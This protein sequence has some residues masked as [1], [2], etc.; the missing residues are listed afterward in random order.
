MKSLDLYILRQMWTPFLFATVTV[1]AIVW[2]TQS[3]QRIDIIVEH[4][5]TL[6]MFGWLTLLIIPSLLAVIIPFGLFAA[7]VFALQKLHSDSEIAVMFAAGVSRAE[8]ARPILL[9]TLIGAA[10]TLWINV[11]LMP[12]T[13]RLLKREI[14]DIRAD[15]ASAIIRSGE[16]ITIKDG[17]T[18]YVDSIGQNGQFFGLLVH[19]YRN[20]QRAE[21]YMAEKALLKETGIGPVLYLSNGNIQRFNGKSGEVDLVFFN[22]TAI[23]LGQFDRGGGDLQLEMTERYLSELFHPDITK[24]YDRENAKRLVGEGHGRLAAP[25]YAFAYVL[26]AIYALIGGPYDRR[27]Y[28]IRI[29]AA[30]ATVG[31]LRVAGYILQGEASELGRYWIVYAV[32]VAAILISG[33]LI[34]GAFPKGGRRDS[35]RTSARKDD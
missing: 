29:A 21:T 15:F 6:T 23:N 18:V 27:G 13:Y 31:G 20:G 11:D 26:I 10:A 4:G 22:H 35:P 9:V 19:D 14:A 24:A 8:I 1:T 12:R 17:F 5:Q 7:A 33:T 34:T 16:F 3:L 2:L 32:P 30:C 25:L 28:A